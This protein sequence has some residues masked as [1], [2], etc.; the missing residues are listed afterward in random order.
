M[1]IEEDLELLACLRVYHIQFSLNDSNI[2]SSPN[3]NRPNVL[4]ILMQNSKKSQLPPA[5]NCTFIR[6]DL[7]Y[8]HLLEILREKELGWT[9]SL[10]LT[11]RK[12]F[13]KR[14]TNLIWYIDPHRH[15]FIRRSF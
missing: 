9:G 10:Q 6:T 12:E 4:E 3:K 11:V 15:K 1:G 2:L 8:N 7:L 5:K 14:L 13:V